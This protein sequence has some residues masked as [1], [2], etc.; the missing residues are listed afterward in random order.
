[1]TCIALDI[2]I[3]NVRKDALRAFVRTLPEIGGVGIYASGSP[4]GH[5]LGAQLGLAQK[6]A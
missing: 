2:Y 5:R 3:T 4:H 6:V 1:M